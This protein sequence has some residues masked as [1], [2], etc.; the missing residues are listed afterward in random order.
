MLVQ[1]EQIDGAPGRIVDAGTGLPHGPFGFGNSIAVLAI[2]PELR[3]RHLTEVTDSIF[4]RQ[5]GHEKGSVVHTLIFEF[6]AHLLLLLDFPHS[7]LRTSAATCPLAYRMFTLLPGHL[8]GLRGLYTRSLGCRRFRP[9]P[10]RAATCLPACSMKLRFVD[11]SIFCSSQAVQAERTLPLRPSW[12]LRR[13]RLGP[14]PASSLGIRLLCWEVSTG[15]DPSGSAL[16]L[17][18]C[19]AR[20]LPVRS[21][22]VMKPCKA[23]GCL[24]TIV[25]YDSSSLSFLSSTSMSEIN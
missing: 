15:S 4:L 14:D 8:A 22:A 12:L 9:G 3:P 19:H 6:G 24:R 25:D 21:I 16:H 10:S 17:F 13:L 18:Q 23:D 5:I 1:L 20:L 2:E 11:N 7:A